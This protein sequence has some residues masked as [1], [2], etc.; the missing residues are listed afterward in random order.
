MGGTVLVLGGGGVK[1]LA[2]VGAW[3]ALV[4]AGVE[5][6]A[7]VGTSIGSLVGAS[8]AGGRSCEEL[9]ERALAL[10]KSDIVVVN[11]W[12]LL[13]NGIRQTS[14]FQG[15]PFRDYI[16]GALPAER[17]DDLRLPLEINAVDLESGEEVWFGARGRTD[18]GLAEAVY[19]S[20][21]L[22][23]FYP[24]AEIGGRHYVDGGVADA[25]P[26]ERAAE[27]EPDRIVAVDVGAGGARDAADTV[28]KGLVAVHHRVYDIMN[29]TRKR[30]RLDAWSGPPLTLVRPRL[31]D[32]ST[33][34][35]GATA[36]FVDEGYR[37][38][39]EALARL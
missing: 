11:R 34:D 33:F 10:T 3:R 24:P 2:H 4:E 16:V 31:D 25:L 13:L 19:A 5:V 8:I 22:P 37:A 9:E 29:Y 18:V 23:V 27:R 30:Q 21:A 6:S 17:F 26:V 14:V 20:S 28:S 32:H 1:G 12:T 36:W 39:K 15:D 38:T 35:F 7:I